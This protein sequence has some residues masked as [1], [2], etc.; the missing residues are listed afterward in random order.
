M[1]AFLIG[2]TII[3]NSSINEFSAMKHLKIIN[4][5][6]IGKY[7][8][9][10]GKREMTY[11]GH[12]YLRPVVDK[13]KFLEAFS[14]SYGKKSL[15][16]KIILKGLNLLDA[17]LDKDGIVIPGKTT[18]MLAD[19]DIKKLKLL[20]GILNSTL[21]LFYIKEKYPASSYN[22][23]TTFTTDMI[24]NLPLPPLTEVKKNQLISIVDKIMS[25]VSLND[26]FESEEKQAKV[27]DCERQIDQ[28]VY[29]LYGLTKDEIKIVEGSNSSEN[30]LSE[31]MGRKFLAQASSKNV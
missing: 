13:K 12:K 21:P 29:E 7:Y 10:W 30:N 9:K 25:I 11:L 17:C 1:Y 18:L 16:P 3:K 22:Q 15:Q 28:M 2:D 5:G 6:T 31:K 20:L 19:N 27:K 26:F 24:D 23:G 4:T 8:P 14:N